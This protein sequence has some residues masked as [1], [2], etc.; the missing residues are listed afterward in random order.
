MSRRIGYFMLKS[1]F[2]MCI[3]LISSLQILM[4]ACKS[5]NSTAQT[6]N[7]PIHL[8]TPIKPTSTP[9]Y[10][11]ECGDLYL[12][13]FD[14]SFSFNGIL[15]G[16]TPEYEIRALIGDPIKISV[17]D[18]WV[19]DGYGILINKN[20]IVESVSFEG[21]YLDTTRSYEDVFS[22]YGCPDLIIVY[23]P[24]EPPSSIFSVVN[25]VYV[26]LGLTIIS[27]SFPVELTSTPDL[28]IFEKQETLEE[29][30]SRI[31]IMPNE[32][33]IAFWNE[34]VK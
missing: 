26:K 5:N 7:T 29:Y 2:L 12:P 21:S 6:S 30:L 4:Y 3:I 1:N 16:K 18:E 32:A 13:Q 11:E 15:P 33:K 20:N 24:Y 17:V 34:V 10:L 19:Y 14:P 23:D 27:Y 9:D 25:F 22:N 28:V 31:D 8:P